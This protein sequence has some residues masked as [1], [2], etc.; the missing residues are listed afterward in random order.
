MEAEKLRLSIVNMV[1]FGIEFSE[2]LKIYI[3]GN[4]KSE[5]LDDQFPTGAVVGTPSG[6]F[7]G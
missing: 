3:P 2:D 7:T 4:Q 1:V 5:A 6:R